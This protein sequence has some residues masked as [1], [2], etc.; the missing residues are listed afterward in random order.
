MKVCIS[1]QKDVGGRK[2][3]RVKEDRVIRVIR[4]VKNA[5]RVAQNNELYV[6]EEDIKAHQERRRGFER[7][8]LLA[9]ILAGVIVLLFI[10]T[11]LL[12]GKLDAWALVSSILLAL[13]ILAFPLFRYAPALEGM[14]VKPFGKQP[15]A[16]M[17]AA[18]A[19]PKRAAT[20]LQQERP[21]QKPK[22]K[23][24]NKEVL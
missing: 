9:G 10:V 12:S 15:P 13:V 20:R 1:C 7:S 19:A 11:L 22:A 2:A 14:P 4:A 18:A 6:C 16:V 23:T 21:D 5:L 17:P 8:M 3:V 24:R